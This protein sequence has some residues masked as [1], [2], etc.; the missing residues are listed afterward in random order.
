[1]SNPKKFHIDTSE[2]SANLTISLF[3]YLQTIRFTGALEPDKNKADVLIF[4]TPQG[5]RKVLTGTDLVISPGQKWI[6]GIRPVDTVPDKHPVIS[7]QYTFKWATDVETC[8]QL[9]QIIRSVG[10]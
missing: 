7:A 10:G 3:F 4:L 5:R 9:E 2:V 1:V 6:I 8:A